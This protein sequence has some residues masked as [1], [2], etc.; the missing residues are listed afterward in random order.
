[1]RSILESLC[2]GTVTGMSFSLP[3]DRTDKEISCYDKIKELL[4]E[5]NAALLEEYA[6]TVTVNYESLILRAYKQ[7]FATAFAL[8]AEIFDAEAEKEREEET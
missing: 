1:M 2:F 7:A 3:E 6:E 4:K 8:A 5:D